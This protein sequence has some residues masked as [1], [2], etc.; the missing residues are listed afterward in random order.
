M[1]LTKDFD[2][3]VNCFQVRQFIVV[4]VHTHAEE[5]AGVTPVD[6][7]VVAELVRVTTAQTTT[8][9]TGVPRGYTPR[10]SWIGISGR[11]VL[12]AG[13]PR[14]ANGPEKLPQSAP[15]R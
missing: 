10:Q 6:N 13:A 4:R 15:R 7:L 1:Q 8:H 14:H 2:E 11:G 5:Q 12:P 3:Q 9:V